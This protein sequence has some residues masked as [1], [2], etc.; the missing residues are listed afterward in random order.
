LVST[1]SRIHNHFHS[2]VITLAPTRI[3]R[4]AMPPF[5]HGATPPK[6]HPQRNLELSSRLSTS[7]AVN[8]TVPLREIEMAD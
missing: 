7:A 8:L 1:H 4:L 5:E 2:S 3:G 6:L